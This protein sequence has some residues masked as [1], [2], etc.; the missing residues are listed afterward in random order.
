M[1]LERVLSSTRK[2]KLSVQPSRSCRIW[3]VVKSESKTERG[4]GEIQ[5][6][7]TRETIHVRFEIAATEM[8]TATLQS[9]AECQITSQAYRVL[10]VASEIVVEVKQL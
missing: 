5:I 6:Q 3:V 4:G 1:Q 9:N 8:F 10:S 2:A 7:Y